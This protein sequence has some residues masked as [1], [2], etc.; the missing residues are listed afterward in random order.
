MLPLLLLSAV[1]TVA[2]VGTMFDLWGDDDVDT[3]NDID[4]DGGFDLLDDTLP[5]TLAAGA[6][7]EIEDGAAVIDTEAV[8]D[9]FGPEGAV[10]IE[11]T[12]GNDIIL[13]GTDVE[14]TFAG[15]G[16]DV[17]FGAEHDQV[18]FGDQGNDVL[19]GEGGAEQMHGDEGDDTLVGG[20][21]S[22][23]I[24]GG[25]GADVIYGGTGDDTIYS[26]HVYETELEPDTF[27]VVAAGTGDDA[28]Y[29]SQG[30]AL[31]SLGEGADDVMIHSD[32]GVEDN[33]P[34]AVIT[35]FDP[36]TDQILLGVHV[37]SFDF[38]AGTT[39]LEI[40]YSLSEIETSAG[41]A[42]LVVPAVEDESLAGDLQDASVGHAVLIGVTPDQIQDNNVLVM[43]TDDDS[44]RFA[45][46]S[47]HAA[48]DEQSV[49]AGL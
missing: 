14:V 18:I 26:A 7:G 25:Q 39:T 38:E 40:G 37:T 49:G 28:I 16:D 36:A 4:N 1:A 23:L 11:G 9:D 31:I 32:F 13:A 34:V 47:I 12:D 10:E 19:F 22:D 2:L 45:D 43:V 27:D 8:R 15:A 3:L 6:L 29:V 33:D 44:P 21:G 5:E 24:V 35:D 17:V 46:D 48:F 42:T 20:D 30:A 41:M